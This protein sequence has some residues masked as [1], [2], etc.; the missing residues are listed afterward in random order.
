M[1]GLDGSGY[2]DGL[3]GEDIPITARILT[4]VDVYDALRT[5]RPYKPAFDKQKSFPILRKE[6]DKGWYDLKVFD[7]IMNLMTEEA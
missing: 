4:V 1:S 7:T 3:K 6:T 5:E 2:P